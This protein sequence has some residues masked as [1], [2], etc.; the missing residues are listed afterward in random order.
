MTKHYNK[1]QKCAQLYHWKQT[2]SVSIIVVLSTMPEALVHLPAALAE[3]AL[4]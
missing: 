4:R 3:F 1:S 2:V